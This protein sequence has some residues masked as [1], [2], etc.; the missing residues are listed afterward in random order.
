MKSKLLLTALAAAI[1]LAICGLYQ[2]SVPADFPDDNALLTTLRQTSPQL[3]WN[4]VITTSG[5]SIVD[6][7]YLT[8]TFAK[9]EKLKDQ[10]TLD[11]RYKI[12]GIE[13]LLLFGLGFYEHSEPKLRR[14]LFAG[15]SRYWETP[16]MEAL[17]EN[18]RRLGQQQLYEKIQQQLKDQNHQKQDETSTAIS[19]S[20]KKHVQ[21]IFLFAWLFILLFPAIIIENERRAWIAKFANLRDPR[22]PF[23]AF[24]GSS[25]P[26]LLVALSAIIFLVIDIPEHFTFTSK[27]LLLLFHIFMA[28]LLCQWPNWLLEKQVKQARSGFIAYIYEKLIVSVFL[29]TH[30]FALLLAAI[31]VHFMLDALPMWP[32][33]EPPSAF[34]ALVAL[35]SAYLTIAELLLPYLLLLKKQKSSMPFRIFLAKGNYNSGIAETGIFSPLSTAVIFGDLKQQ[36]ND[37]EIRL[38]FERSKKRFKSGQ[39]FVDY[40]VSLNFILIMMLFLALSPLHLIRLFS[41]GPTFAQ[42]MAGILLMLLCGWFRHNLRKSSEMAIDES[43]ADSGDSEE[44]IKALEK[45]NRLNS[46]PD[47]VRDGELGVFDTVSLDKIRQTLRSQEGRYFADSYKPDSALL[48]SL[49]RSRLALDWNMGKDEA[50]FV[51]SLDYQVNAEN[52]KDELCAL[53]GKHARL[54]AECLLRDDSDTLEIIYCYQK[55]SA[56]TAES[57]LP[58]DKICKICS[59]AMQ[60]SMQHGPYKWESSHK[61]CRL[62]SV[63]TDESDQDTA[64]N[65]S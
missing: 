52:I 8:T 11:D 19:P 34:F 41:A 49:W 53:A 45:V 58:Q 3:F 25:L 28:W 9:F 2:Q 15:S 43:F 23:Q 59:D 13:G 47:H 32:I 65:D 29:H 42:A 44:F 1:F 38:L 6:T 62:V 51:T 26:N 20:T 48:V 4:A 57:P 14:S 5:S 18:Y 12:E 56:L 31:S 16:I 50:V 39:F 24:S 27:F 64:S 60:K 35:F 30:L 17:K 40:L 33:N 21:L 36:L 37:N 46:K 55:V 22:G 63:N 7:R 61:G 10:L 54:G